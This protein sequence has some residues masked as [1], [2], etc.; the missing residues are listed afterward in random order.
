MALGGDASAAIEL[1]EVPGVRLDQ[2]AGP[3]AA[4]LEQV[5]VGDVDPI[6]CSELHERAASAVATKRSARAQQRGQQQREQQ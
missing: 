2:R 3:V 4:R 1:H 5:R 6:V